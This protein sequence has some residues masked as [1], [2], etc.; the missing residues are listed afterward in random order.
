MSNESSVADKAPD[1]I[2]D[3]QNEAAVSVKR[4]ALILI[5]VILLSVIWYLVSD[6]FAP[7][8]TQARIQG[9]VV[10]VA[11]KVS[12]LITKVLVK[13]NE[14]VKAG[15]PV[16]EIDRSQYEIALNKA[17]SDLVNAHS[18]VNAGDATVESARANLLAVQANHV[19][20]KQDFNRLS[21][22]Y[23]QDP[24]TI[25]KRRIEISQA[26]LE[27]AQASVSAAKA[28][29]SRAIE[30]KGGD[31]K[32]NNAILQSAQSAVAKAALD[33]ENTNVKAGARGVITDL[34]ADVG[35]Y[36]SAGQAAMTLV[37]MHDVWINAEYT[38]NNLGHLKKGGNV[39]ILFDV[40]PGQIFTGS[41]RSIGL[42]VSAGKSTAPGTLP[43]IENNR[44]WLRQSQRFPV[45]ININP[46][47][48]PELK[49][50]LRIGGQASIIA[51][52]E[53]H[54][55]TRFFGQLYIRLMSILSYAY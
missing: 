8:T 46:E 41:I 43:S 13:N 31:D 21:R 6:R 26:S 52:T 35:Q 5:V 49:S 34:N 9:Y 44:D 32:A 47:H 14:E 39:E 36:V 15:Q 54:G 27:Q 37:A 45:I 55:F 11:P 29:I 4:S 53:G 17:K 22:L 50:N 25:S 1:N 3:S 51:Y 38:E 16:F 42:G 18:Q 40:L 23:K 20:A 33:L 28:E 2:N 19:K 24:G 30:Q 7:Y 10:G 12:G 48:H